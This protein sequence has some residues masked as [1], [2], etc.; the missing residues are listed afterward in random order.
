MAYVVRPYESTPRITAAKEQLSGLKI[1]GTE[2]VVVSGAG[3]AIASRY[4][5]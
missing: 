5:P 3:M 1:G 2:R 4:F